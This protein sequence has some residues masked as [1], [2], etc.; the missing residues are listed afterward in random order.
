LFYVFS[1][2]RNFTFQLSSRSDKKKLRKGSFLF[3]KFSKVK[4]Q[5]KYNA[6]WKRSEGA[7]KARKKYG[8]TKTS[9]PSPFS[10]EGQ[11]KSNVD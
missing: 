10:I 11:R 9:R 3:S 8:E 5:H 4:Q 1:S 2:L 7:T 6:K